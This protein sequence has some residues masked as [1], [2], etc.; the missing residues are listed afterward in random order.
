MRNPFSKKPK[1]RTIKLSA[2]QAK[3]LAE[4]VA[5]E[6]RAQAVIAQLQ[7]AAKAFIDGI[8]FGALTPD[9]VSK[10]AGVETRDGVL[11]VSFEQPESKEAPTS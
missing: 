3:R 7:D 2:A 8:V 9:E 4:I 1:E 11:V 10:L 5:A 6:R